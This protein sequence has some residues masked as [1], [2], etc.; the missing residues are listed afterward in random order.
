MV[1][2]CNTFSTLLQFRPSQQEIC[3]ETFEKLCSISFSQ[4]AVNETVEA[5]YSPVEK[6]CGGE[7]PVQCSTVFESAC[8]TRY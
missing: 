6:V 4:K 7:G 1:L 5:C 8:T 2:C 3:E